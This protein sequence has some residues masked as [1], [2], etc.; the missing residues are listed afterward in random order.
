[1]VRGVALKV[2][3]VAG[4]GGWP[5]LWPDTYLRRLNQ[6]NEK[7]AVT[8]KALVKILKLLVSRLLF[9]SFFSKAVGY[10]PC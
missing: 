2:V 9:R 5:I 3:L 7:I 10:L 4:V 6:T 1:M 8:Q